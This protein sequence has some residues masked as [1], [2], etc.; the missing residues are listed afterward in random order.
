M[1]LDKEQRKIDV[2][3]HEPDNENSPTGASISGIYGNQKGVI[4]ISYLNQ[5]V[6]KVNINTEE[7]QR[8]QEKTGRLE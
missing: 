8:L 4:W 2:L 1:N 5:G 3:A 6:S 7:I